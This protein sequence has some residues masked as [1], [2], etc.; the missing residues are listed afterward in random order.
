[1]K[2]NRRFAELGSRREISHGETGGRLV[3]H[4][5]A[6]RLRVAVLIPCYNEA[7]AIERVVSDFKRVL[8]HAIIYVYDNN[9]QDNTADMAGKAG[10]VTRKEMRQGKG[11]V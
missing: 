9:S 11:F 7:V 3:T 8:P 4:A 10:A 6:S 1:M 2:Q 5:D